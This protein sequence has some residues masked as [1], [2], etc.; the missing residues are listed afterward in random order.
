M[1]T[2]KDFSLLLKDIKIDS[3]G[4]NFICGKNALHI[5]NL[6][7]DE[8]KARKLNNENIR[9]AVDYDPLGNLTITGRYYNNENIDLKILANLIQ[10]TSKYLPYYKALAINGYFFHDAGASIVQELGYCISMASE[11]LSQLTDSGISVDSICHNLQFNLGIGTNYF[12]EIAKIRALRFLWAKIAEAYQT[13]KDES[14]KTFIHSITSEWNQTIYNPYMNL[15]RAT[16]E[17]M[18]AIIGGTNSLVVRPFTNAY[19][20]TTSFANRLSRNIQ[21]I[22]NEEAYLGKVVDPGAGSYYIE[23]LTNSIIDESWKLFLTIEAEGGYLNALKKGLIQA[24]MEA[25]AQYRNNAIANRREVLVGTNQYPDFEESV[26]NE[27]HE[28]IVFPARN[29]E[30]TSITPLKIYRASQE[31][32]KLRLATEK[33]SHRPTVFILTYG[34]LA[35][36]RARATFACNFFACAGYKIMDNPGFS[37][38]EKGIE[39]ANKA[40]ADIVV[41]CSCD[42][43]YVNIALQVV[44]NLTKNSIL[45]IAGAPDCM[46]ELQALGI[47]NFI[48]TRSDVLET[49]KYY[50]KILGITI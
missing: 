39:A 9:G 28:E 3:I 36:R 20:P 42:D 17:S 11:Y 50:H 24:E 6:L 41:L 23:N 31:F 46:D 30:N 12:M 13:V 1:A 37:E 25:T 8:I 40:K 44:K 47:T 27:I 15:L 21:I 2:Q 43:E 5:L 16:T 49:L 35:L 10:F 14:K 33:H 38:I 34:D 22:L 4:L 29:I 45:V 18:S 19:K 48:H 26:K 7:Y 32:E